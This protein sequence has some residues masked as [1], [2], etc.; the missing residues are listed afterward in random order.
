[1]IPDIGWMTIAHIPCF[2]DGTYV[3]CASFFAS[4]QEFSQ[5][6]RASVFRIGVSPHGSWFIDYWLV[7]WNMSFMTFHN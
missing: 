7:V 2:D 1:M 3:C 6:V 4:P 5:V